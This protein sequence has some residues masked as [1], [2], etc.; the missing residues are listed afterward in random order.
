MKD[1]LF[2]VKLWCASGEVRVIAPFC[3]RKSVLTVMCI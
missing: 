3:S 2:K 1:L